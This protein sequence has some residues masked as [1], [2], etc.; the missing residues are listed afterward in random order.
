[1]WFIFI[2]DLFKK[3]AI[4]F[5]S[6]ENMSRKSRIKSTYYMYTYK[7]FLAS[8]KTIIHKP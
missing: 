3:L 4:F 1:M 8:C 5:Q 2:N 7:F 6:D